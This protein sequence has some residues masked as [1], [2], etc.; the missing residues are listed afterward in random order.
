MGLKLERLMQCMDCLFGRRFSGA[1]AT[2]NLGH[3]PVVRMN[4]DT[5]IPEGWGVGVIRGVS[6]LHMKFV[7]LDAPARK[8]GSQ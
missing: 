3:A 6:L 5:G 8:R 4:V 7:I 2:G 1:D